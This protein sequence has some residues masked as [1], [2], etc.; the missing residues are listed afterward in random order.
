MNELTINCSLENPDRDK[1]KVIIDVENDFKE[2]MLYKYIIGC[3]GIW[4]VLKNFTTERSVVWIPDGDGKYIVMIQAKKDGSSKSFDYISRMNYIIGDIR[5]KLIKGIILDKERY[6]LGDK[7]KVIVDAQKYPLM[8]RYWIKVDGQWRLVKDYSSENTF[9]YTVRSESDGEILVECKDVCSKNDFDDFKKAAFCVHRIKKPEIIDFKCL[10]KEL[11]SGSEISFQVLSEYEEDR[12]VLYKFFKINSSGEAICIQNYSTMR[13]VSYVEENEGKYKLLCFVKDMYSKNKFDD[14]AV[15]NFEIKKYS[16]I[17]IKSFTTDLSS[18]QLTNTDVTITT[19]VI[20]GKELLYRYVAEGPEN[21]DSGYIRSSS[22]V[23]RSRFPGKYR[24]ILFVKDKSCSKD[25]ESC[26]NMGFVI[27][28]KSSEPVNIESMVFDVTDKILKNQSV[29]AVVYASGGNDLRYGFIIK[30]SGNVIEKID[31]GYKNWI[32]FIPRDSGNYEIEACVRDSYSERKYDSH[33]IKSIDVYDYIPANI[34]YILYPIREYYMVGDRILISIVTQDTTNVLLK[35]VL[36]INGHIVEE[37]DFIEEK[38]YMLIPKCSGKYT[39]EVMAKNIKSSA[40]FDCKKRLNMQIR[41]T[42]PITET[43]LV[44]QKNRYIV[45]EP[46]TFYVHNEGGRNSLYEFYLME[47]GNWM[48]V[49]SYSRK[50]NYT[51]IP[52]NSEEYK[53]M[54]LCKDEFSRDVYEDY[55]IFTFKVI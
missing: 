42:V 36:A 4:K 26:E 33:I 27:D 41:E 52:F 44:C 24:L 35:Y 14:R 22:Y 31:Y 47:K 28:E 54:V 37:T 20:G 18:P 50:D 15:L 23:W 53:I 25:Y 43:K 45:N 17:F 51:F 32:Q 39:L 38:S 9:T 5:E 29:K 10:N 1:K 12:T 48:L 6:T 11:I 8:F 7:I 16:P 3:G 2:D 55:D 30:K 49:Q 34:D 46:V 21:Q 19:D 40:V 13:T